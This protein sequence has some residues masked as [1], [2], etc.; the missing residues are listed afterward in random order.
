MTAPT[1]PLRA[2]SP[3]VI[4]DGMTA[5]TVGF[6]GTQRGC[7]QVQMRSLYRVVKQLNPRSVRHGDC[8]G[9]DTQFHA[10]VRSNT[11]AKVIGH[12]PTDPIKRAWCECDSLEPEYPYLVR[13]HN[14]VNASDV[15]I[16]TPGES[17]EV[18]RSGTWATIRYARKMKKPL[19]IIFPDGSVKLENSTNA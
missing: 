2:P 16:A 19:W 3:R 14:I 15:M 12:P 1:A 8:I 5:Q 18:V 11:T 13:N 7:S 4:L 17:Y 10:V 9:A 6:T